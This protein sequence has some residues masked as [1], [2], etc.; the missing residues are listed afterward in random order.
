MK[1]N[2]NKGFMLTEI[3]VTSTLVCTVLIFLYSQF[4]SIKRGYDISFKY[5]TVNGLYASSNI[6]NYLID[7]GIDAMKQGLE[8]NP[9]IDLKEDMLGIKAPA[10]WNL[11]ISSLNI[12]AILF[13]KADLTELISNLNDLDSVD[14]DFKRFVRHI[15]FD[16]NSNDY[17]LIIQYS[18]DTFASILMGDGQNEE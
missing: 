10:Y 2:D 11:L 12:K 7:N 8:I 1:K 14:E 5:N 4:Y 6:K 3:L 15:D 13:S 9:C 18:D 17:R 16:E